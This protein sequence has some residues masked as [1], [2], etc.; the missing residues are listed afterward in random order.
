MTLNAYIV[1]SLT[2]SRPSL[3][4]EL[5]LTPTTHTHTLTG[6]LTP[7]THTHPHRSSHTHP[8]RSSHTHHT[9]THPHRS[10]HAH[11]TH[12]PPQELSR[13]P[14]SPEAVFPIGGAVHKQSESHQRTHQLHSEY[15]TPCTTIASVQRVRQHHVPDCRIQLTC[16]SFSNFA[17][18]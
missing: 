5:S 11:H 10:S 13:P 3:T 8:H 18:R 15:A 7:T 9:H 17:A 6:A 16:S 2:P 12:T 4:Q 14:S 1:A